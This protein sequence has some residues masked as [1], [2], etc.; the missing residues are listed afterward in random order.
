LNERLEEDGEDDALERDLG[1]EELLTS[2]N[3]NET[4]IPNY[5]GLFD[6]DNSDTTAADTSTTSPSQTKN[7]TATPSTASTAES[8]NASITTHDSPSNA[9][10]I[11]KLSY[12]CPTNMKEP[13]FSR[14]GTIAAVSKIVLEHWVPLAFMAQN[15]M[16]VEKNGSSL[17]VIAS[18]LLD[19]M[20][21]KADPNQQ[22]P[23][24]YTSLR[25]LVAFGNSFFDDHMEWAKR[26]D[27]V[28][29]AG[30]YGHI[31]RLVPEHLFVMHEQFE[32]LKNG[33]WKNKPEFRGFI[34]AVQGVI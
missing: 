19:L 28:F 33:G 20:S 1:I 9:S 29:G 15:I 3:N 32:S 22:S 14:W 27:P 7:I 6:E 31:S 18:R 24:H 16:S 12:N 10:A 5:L 11:K 21:S 8:T 23:T 17:H 30:S 13:N 25:W 4:P 26:H 34:K 2:S